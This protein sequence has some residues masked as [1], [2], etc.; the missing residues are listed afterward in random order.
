MICA[1]IQGYELKAFTGMGEYFNK[2]KYVI[3]EMPIANETYFNAP[4]KDIFLQFMV[5]NNFVPKVAVR[6]NVF[7]INVLFQRNG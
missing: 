5:K 1:D 4:N 2:V 6:E 7:E 3:T